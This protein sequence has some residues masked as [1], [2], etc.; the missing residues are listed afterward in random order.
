LRRLLA[1]P[2]NHPGFSCLFISDTRRLR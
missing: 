1:S 2:P